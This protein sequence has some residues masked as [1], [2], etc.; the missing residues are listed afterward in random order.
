MSNLLDDLNDAVTLRVTKAFDVTAI[1]KEVAVKGLICRHMILIRVL[2]SHPVDANSSH[3]TIKF[4]SRSRPPTEP[5]SSTTHLWVSILWKRLERVIDDVANC[6]IK[7]Y[8]LEKVL[9]IKRDT[10]TQ[11]EFFDEVMKASLMM[12]L[13]S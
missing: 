10:L 2:I 5:T 12:P 8:T 1:G 3:G 9:R 4:P 7:V 6:C 11:V 13:V